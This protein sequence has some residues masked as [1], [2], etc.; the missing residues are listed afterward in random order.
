MTQLE[1]AEPASVTRRSASRFLNA[2][3]L[4]LL[5]LAVLLIAAQIASHGAFMQP[6]NLLNILAQNSITGTLAV[7]QTIVIL[8]GGIDLSLGSITALSSMVTLLLQDQGP[9]IARLGGLGVGVACGAINGLLVV[10]GRVPPFIATLGM[11]QAALGMT[12]IVSNG[13]PVYEN[14][15]MTLVFGLDRIGAVPL[16]ILL[17]LFVALVAW[18]LLRFTRFGASVYAIGGNE[19]TAIASGVKVGWTKFLI[20]A[21]AGLCA[22]VAGII[23]INRLGYSQPTLGASFTLDSIAPVVLGGTSLLG[24]VG[25]IVPTLGGVVVAGVLNNLMVLLGVNIYAEQ[26]VQGA[27]ILA[28]VFFFIRFQRR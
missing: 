5:L 26:I 14:D 4:I 25:G 19:R 16:I 20:Y 6:R 1:S 28:F 2:R 27:I 21:I 17:W 10:Y 23:S 15:H 8:S 22:A 3:V 24:G 7:G 18:I 9:L 13:Y 11:M 12:Y